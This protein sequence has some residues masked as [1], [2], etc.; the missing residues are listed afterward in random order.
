MFDEEDV[1][2]AAAALIEVL[3]RIKQNA[4]EY[5]DFVRLTNL[6]VNAK[7]VTCPKI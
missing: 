5:F 6:E 4:R 2:L 3:Y 7:R 1:L